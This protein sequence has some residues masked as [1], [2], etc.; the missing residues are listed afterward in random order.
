[1]RCPHCDADTKAPAM[2]TRRYA[3]YTYRRR[4][5]PSCKNSFVTQETA[6]HGLKMPRPVRDSRTRGVL[7]I[8]KCNERERL[9]Y[10][11]GKVDFS[12]LNKVW[13]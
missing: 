2:E 11:E 8:E 12:E 13:S 10:E 6:P 5:C 9:R 3:G 1:M 7:D 4:F